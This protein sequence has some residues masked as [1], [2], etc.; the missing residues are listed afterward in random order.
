M[1]CCVCWEDQLSTDFSK[2]GLKTLPPPSQLT[3]MLTLHSSPVFLPN[4]FFL[5]LLQM[6]SQKSVLKQ[7]QPESFVK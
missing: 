1:H 5:C 2:L 7:G 6:V 4:M 3:C